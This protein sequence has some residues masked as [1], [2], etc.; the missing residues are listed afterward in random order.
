MFIAVLPDKPGP[1]EKGTNDSQVDKA[2]ADYES[3]KDDIRAPMQEVR[4][5]N[6]Y[7]AVGWEPFMGIG[8]LL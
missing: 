2:L 6:G 3:R 5:S 7:R 1:V 8:V 4:L